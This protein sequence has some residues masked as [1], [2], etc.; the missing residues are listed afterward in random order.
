MTL[1][2]HLRDRYLEVALHG[3][4]LESDEVVRNVGRLE[5]RCEQ[6][7]RSRSGVAMGQYAG[8]WA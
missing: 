8:E 3:A 4:A 5:I 6:C 7:P 1:I 2:T